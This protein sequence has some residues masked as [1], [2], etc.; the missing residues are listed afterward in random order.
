MVISDGT[1]S[2]PEERLENA[3]R[4]AQTQIASG[5]I[6]GAVIAV[7]GGPAA[8]AG[9]QCV[10][11]AEKP[12]TVHSRF[13]IASVGKVFTAACC[14]LLA[15]DGELE[16]DAPFTR[17]LPEHVLGKSCNITVR[18]LAMHAGGFDNSK[19]YDSDDVEI[20]N[21]ELFG[22]RPVRPRLEAFEYACSNF[23]LLGKIAER[24]SGT[25][26]DTLARERIWKPLGMDRTQW[27]PP[28]DGDDEVE[29]WFPNRPA[30]RHN[31][32]ICYLCPFPLGSGSCFST[33]RDLLLFARDILERGRF[34]GAYYDLITSCR[35][36]KNGIRRSFGWDMTDSLRS[37][38]LSAGTI[39]HSG[40]TGQT[41]C[42]DPATKFAAVVLTSRT[43]DHEEA[44]A[45]RK[46]IIEAL[47]GTPPV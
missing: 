8:A 28:G 2:S 23:I 30:G 3:R 35:F 15:A 25:D 12:M 42:I 34:P 27:L 36:A 9:L 29:H 14:A 22:K 20:F 4:E 45:G 39:F 1:A 16:P 46:R 40:W 43:G 6:Q 21:R 7:A 10:H 44:R 41:L 47:Y 13:D 24:I 31:D 17:Y 18:D 33:A 11:P 38:G 37:R 26:L 32:G 5:L 19:P